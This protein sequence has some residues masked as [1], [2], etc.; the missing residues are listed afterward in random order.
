MKPNKYLLPLGGIVLMLIALY[1]A[2][3]VFDKTLV[4]AEDSTVRFTVA[5]FIWMFAL[6]LCAL[7]HGVI[8]RV[9]LKRW[10]LPHILWFSATWIGCACILAAPLF[11]TEGLFWPMFTTVLSLM[12]SLLTCLFAKYRQSWRNDP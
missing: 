6:P 2:T 8:T 7:A 4:S 10:L 3:S 5:D 12:A 9:T 11:S 1:A